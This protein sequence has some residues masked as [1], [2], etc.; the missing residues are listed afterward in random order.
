MSKN[1][2]GKISKRLLSAF[3]LFL[4]LVPAREFSKSTQKLYLYYMRREIEGG[5]ENFFLDYITDAIALFDLLE[6]IEEE[7]DQSELI[8]RACKEED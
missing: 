2:N 4:S 7:Y 6:K 5:V 3:E 8:N 1:K